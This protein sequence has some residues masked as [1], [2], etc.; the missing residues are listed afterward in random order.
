MIGGWLGSWFGGWSGGASTVADGVTIGNIRDRMIAIVSEI[1]PLSL[2]ADPFT[3]WRSDTEIA[4][5]LDAAPVSAFRR[6]AI[7]CDY[8]E[9]M[10]LVTNADVARLGARMVLAVGYPASH[11]VGNGRDRER[12]MSS[13]ARAIEYA[14]G[15]TGR[16]NFSGSND[17]TP[18]SVDFEIDR[19]S[20][21]I[22]FLLGTVGLMYVSTLG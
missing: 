17:C 22:H 4:A 7:R 9:G 14:I 15:A 6:Y 10:P 11:R 21:A 2:A 12:V 5:A 13:D 19:T 3:P 8:V 20:D 16:R 18:L 1:V